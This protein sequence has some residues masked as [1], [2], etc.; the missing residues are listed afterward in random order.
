MQTI[1]HCWLAGCLLLAVA[2]SSP[3]SPDRGTPA[4]LVAHSEPDFGAYWYAGKAELSRYTLEQARYGSINPGEAVL[5]FVTEDFLTDRQVKLE[6]EPTKRSTPVLKLNFS[7]KFV[8][9]IYDYSLLTSVFTPIQTDRFPRTLKVT[10][11]AQEWCGH[12]FSQ[13]NYRR[14]RYQVAGY[15]YFQNEADEAYAVEGTWLEDELWTRIRLDPQTLPTGEI[16]LVPGTAAARL[17]HQRLQPQPARAELA[18]FAGN[19][20]AGTSL[21]AY[22]LTYPDRTLRI[23]FEKD[24]P[25]LIAGWEDTYPERNRT[26]TTRAVR[27]RTMRTDYWAKNAPRD[28]TLRTELGIK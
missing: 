21:L 23:V 4:T 2:C 16:R 15:S 25:H 20:F 17:R 26:L 6:S 1:H 19:G 11:T 8:T 27:T 3:Q 5:I 18:P 14:N 12:T 24:F 7:R 10:T 28:T 22:T 13:L 9:G